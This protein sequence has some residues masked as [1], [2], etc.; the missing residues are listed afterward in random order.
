MR[1]VIFA[2]ADVGA[3][4]ALE[5]AQK[6]LLILLFLLARGREVPHVCHEAL[7]LVRPRIYRVARDVLPCIL[8]K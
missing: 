1:H 8:P 7:P 5:P 2:R 4:A 3:V 6:Q